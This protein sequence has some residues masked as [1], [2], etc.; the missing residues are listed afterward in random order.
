MPSGWKLTD[1]NPNFYSISG[2]GLQLVLKFKPPPAV[3]T[4]KILGDM[5]A[6]FGANKPY[7]KLATGTLHPAVLAIMTAAEVG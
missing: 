7:K 2:N 4:K 6:D 3:F 1:Q 5:L